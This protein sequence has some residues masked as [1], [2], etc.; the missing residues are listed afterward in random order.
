M[1]R[2]DS[3]GVGLYTRLSGFY[4]G[5]FMTIGVILPYWGLYLK[6]L[7]LTPA[8]IGELLALMM[9]TK[10]VAPNLWGW[11]ADRSG[12]RMVI[13]RLACSA[14]LVCSGTILWAGSSFAM[15][16]VVIVAFSFFWNAALPQF[17]VITLNHLGRNS[18]LYSAIRLWG[19]V[20]FIVSATGIGWL[21]QQLG[22]GVVPLMIVIVFAVLVLASLLVPEGRAVVRSADESVDL[23][24]VL[25]QPEVIVLLT[26]CTLIWASHG[27]YYA[28][29]TIY[30]SELGYRDSLIGGLWSVGVLAE[31]GLFTVMHRLLPRFGTRRLLLVAVVLTAVRWLLIGFLADSLIILLIAQSLH[32]FSF[33]VMHAVAI[34]L[35]HVLF[36][37]SLQGRGQALYSS[38]GTGV[39]GAVGS[40]LAGYL[41]TDI[42][43]QWTY[44]AAAGLSLASGWLVWQ[45]IGNQAAR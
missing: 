14:A 17:E 21:I 33:G 20:G 10:I 27:P 7:E 36:T 42:G 37:G 25:R 6:S 3:L 13:V 12:R 19:S 9:M 39:G 26:V 32:A 28:F 35:I 16:A 44:T 24:P 5:Y 22:V 40:L 4:F 29:F 8:R 31:V 1:S 2:S 23:W 43:P 45:V 38:L 41:W 34:D 30:L 11:L 18:H 15:L